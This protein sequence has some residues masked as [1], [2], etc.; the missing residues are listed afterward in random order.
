MPASRNVSPRTDDRSY[1]AATASSQISR[2]LTIAPGS[3]GVVA[4]ADYPVRQG[5]GKPENR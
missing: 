2:S 4:T 5:I 1:E 3:K